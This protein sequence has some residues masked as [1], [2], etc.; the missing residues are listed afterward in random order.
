M[1]TVPSMLSML[2]SM[3]SDDPNAITRYRSLSHLDLVSSLAFQMRKRST[4]Q[5]HP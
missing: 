3:L 5:S 2:F 4:V 1:L